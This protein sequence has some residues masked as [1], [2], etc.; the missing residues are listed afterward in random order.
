MFLFD[1]EENE[2]VNFVLKSKSKKSQDCNGI[3]MAIVK[4]VILSISKPL[5][6][7]C[8]LSF[9]S[10]T[11]PNSMKIAKV[12]PLYKSGDKHQFTNYTPVALLSQFSK[13]FEKLFDNRLEKCIDKHSLLTNSQYGFRKTRSTSL[14]ITEA[15]EE[16]SNAMDNKKYAIGL[17]IDLKKA[18]DT[19]NH[20]ILVDKLERYGIRGV[21][22]E[23]VK[24]YLSNRKQF[25]N[26]GN[27][28]SDCL[29]ITCGVPQGSVL[30]PKLFI[31]Y[32]N[33]M[34]K[35]SLVLKLVLFADD[36]NIFCSDEHIDTLLDKVTAEMHQLKVWFDCNKL[37]LNLSKTKYM[38]F[39]N[40]KKITKQTLIIDQEIIEKV[41]EF[42][43]LGVLI[44]NKLNWKSH[45][46]YV[47]TKISKS[48]AVLNKVKY[49][50]DYKSLRML[51]C[52]L[53]L[54]HLSYC[55]EIWGNNYTS[56][57][58]P[59]IIL[60]KRAIRIVHWVGY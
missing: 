27:T 18:F 11:F 8:N 13:I 42:K 28:T 45:I 48:V 4:D 43:F 47:Q 36:T 5:T 55:L 17:F 50:L 40:R 2:L 33:D 1:V 23:W 46:K 22:L 20:R 54:P 31:L 57:I 58:K 59:L 16:I 6:Y 53:V 35:V 7:L 56:T 49:V 12:I 37:S 19:I 21:A 32:I 30:G 9:K 29:N 25:V 52:A 41:D 24:N 60:Q 51:Y 44:D 38:I 14:A 3:D 10:G 15:M 39:S 34:S 26:M